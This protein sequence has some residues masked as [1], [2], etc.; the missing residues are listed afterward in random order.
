MVIK[1]LALGE[2]NVAKNL[3]KRK[4]AQV[5]AASLEDFYQELKRIS[6]A[7]ADKDQFVQELLQG[8]INDVTPLS[9]KLLQN[10][11]SVL[12]L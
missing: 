5:K 8:S 9:L 1:K 2:K 3:H 7:T 12:V 11:D 4:L 6:D 10:E